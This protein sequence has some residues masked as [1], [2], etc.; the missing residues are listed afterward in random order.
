MFPKAKVPSLFL[1]VTYLL[2]HAAKEKKKKIHSA[3]HLESS[4]GKHKIYGSSTQRGNSKPQNSRGPA[5]AKTGTGM[6]VWIVRR[7]RTRVMFQAVQEAG[8]EPNRLSS[9]EALSFTLR[10]LHHLGK[11][12]DKFLFCFV[13]IM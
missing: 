5:E 8:C 3:S 13:I 9:L 2:L 10:Y 1:P 11:E 6:W 7:E 12:E 4:K